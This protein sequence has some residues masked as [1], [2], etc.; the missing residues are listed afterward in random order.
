MYKIVSKETLNSAVELMEIEAPFVAAKCEA[1]QFIIVRVDEDGERI[2][3]TI[4]DYDR[5]K[6]TVTIIY[7]IVGYSTEKLA[8]K[9]AGEYVED[10]VGPL[11]QP[12]L[13]HKCGH[14]ISFASFM[15]WA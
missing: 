3:L 10:F 8:K 6:N 5:E 1:G 13:L 9:K 2:P 14:V 11:G 12:A 15:I 7:Q 4:A